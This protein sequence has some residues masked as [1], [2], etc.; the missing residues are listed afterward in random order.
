MSD[1]PAREHTAFLTSVP[2]FAGIPEAELADLSQLL[3]RRE[4][5]AG[6]TL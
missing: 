2:L 5:D 6:Q 4:F 3:R 1:E